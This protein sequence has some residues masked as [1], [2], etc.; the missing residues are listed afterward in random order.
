MNVLF[1]RV[2]VFLQIFLCFYYLSDIADFILN[3]PYFLVPTYF[4]F[5]YFIFKPGEVCECLA[6]TEK[7]R[8][9]QLQKEEKE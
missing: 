8:E 9:N 4:C 3:C 1:F 2:V 6:F 7:E 5:V